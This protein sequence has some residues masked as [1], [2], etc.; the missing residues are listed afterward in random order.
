MYKRMR[1]KNLP[2]IKPELNYNLEYCSSYSV[3]ITIIS[4]ILIASNTC[5]P[6]HSTVNL[7]YVLS[8]VQC[9][10]VSSHFIQ[11]TLLT[12]THTKQFQPIKG[13]PLN[14]HI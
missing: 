9:W 8:L 10:K 14:A 3:T 13:R 1:G 5:N 7:L 12:R 6:I 11:I 4:V 2:L